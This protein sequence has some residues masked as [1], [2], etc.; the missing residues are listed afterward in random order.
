VDP[1]ACQTDLPA[2]ANCVHSVAEPSV[3]YDGKASLHARFVVTCQ[4]FARSQCGAALLPYVK[5]QEPSKV[6][7]EPSRRR[8]KD[9]PQ[10]GPRKAPRARPPGVS[11]A[12]FPPEG[13]LGVRA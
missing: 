2:I 8:R 4:H 7:F 10:T 13:N 9:E 6:V 1:S 12:I 5:V 11:R 3:G